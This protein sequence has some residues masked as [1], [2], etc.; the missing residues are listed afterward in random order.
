MSKESDEL[1]QIIEQ[2]ITGLG[3]TNNTYSELLKFL[4]DEGKLSMPNRLM[5]GYMVFFKYDPVSEAFT[6][7]NRYYDVFPLIFVTEVYK[8]GFEGINLHYLN[9]QRREFLFEE[10]VKSLP[11]TKSKDEW[12]ERFVLNYKRLKSSKKLMYFRPCYKKYRWDGMRK[13]PVLIPHDYWEMMVKQDIGF[14]MHKKKPS[15]YRDSR[16][17][18][19]KSR[20]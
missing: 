11:T 16:Q 14:F 9:L 12:R 1:Q 19:R 6:N 5:P 7:T 10:M 4:K 8:G 18:I 17:I 13:R 15:V 2:T 20:P 3:G